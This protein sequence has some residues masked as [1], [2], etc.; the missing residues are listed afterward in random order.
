MEK[1]TQDMADRAWAIIEE[2]E[3]MGGMTK[4]VESGWA[5]L[6]I[7]ECAADKQAKIDSN[8]DV[9]VGVNKYRLD[10][11]DPR[12][13]PRDRQLGRAR[14]ADRAAEASSRRPRFGGRAAGAGSLDGVR[15]DRRGQ[16][17][18]RDRAGDPCAGHRGRGL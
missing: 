9:I 17:A 15:Q 7:E 12:R 3:S 11:E 14:F 16:L 5:K 2:V 4:A 1:L 10:K 18:G 8:Q 13:V 6:K